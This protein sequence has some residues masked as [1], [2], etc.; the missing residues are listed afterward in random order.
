MEVA[1][2]SA[3]LQANEY[4]R[5]VIV[6]GDAMLPESVRLWQQTPMKS[7]RLLNA[8]GP[9]EATTFSTCHPV[10][11]QDA[12]LRIPIGRPISNTQ[13]YVLDPRFEPAP[14]GL[15]RDA[16]IAHAERRKAR[17]VVHFKRIELIP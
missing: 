8:Y 16:Q 17:I 10:R 6:G 9:T 4:I 5:L 11:A 1:T 3:A 7:A 15:I 13:L 12:D 14:V 2:Q